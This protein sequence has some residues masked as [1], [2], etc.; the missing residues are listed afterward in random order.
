MPQVLSEEVIDAYCIDGRP[1]IFERRDPNKFYIFFY[2]KA[3]GY[4][5]EEDGYDWLLPVEL[6]A[7]DYGISWRVWD[8]EPT[9]EFA[10]ATPWRNGIDEDYP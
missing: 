8:A 6:G 10:A 7:T 5:V 2:D 9:D 3:S 1:I 4:F